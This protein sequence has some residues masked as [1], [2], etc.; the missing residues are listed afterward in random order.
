[1]RPCFIVPSVSKLEQ[2]FQ[3]VGYLEHP[4]HSFIVWIGILYFVG[5][6]LYDVKGVLN[7]THGSD[8]AGKRTLVCLGILYLH[9]EREDVGVLVRGQAFPFGQADI[10]HGIDE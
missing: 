10:A 5:F 9:F 6:A 4:C 8:T 2:R 3:R 7:P 1:M